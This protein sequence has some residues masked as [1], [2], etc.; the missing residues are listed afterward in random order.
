MT[1][2]AAF[3]DQAL[4]CRALGSPLTAQVCDGLAAAL[5]PE[6]GPVAQT[7]LNWPG[8]ASGRANS[9]PLR[10]AGA[11]HF[12]TRAGLV[13]D[14]A[15]AYARGAAPPDLMIR[16][17]QDHAAFVL[18]WLRSPPQTNEVARSAAIIAAAHFLR[19]ALPLAVMELGASAGLN[20]NWHRFRLQPQTAQPHPGFGPADS[21]VIL[22]P[23]W[24]GTPPPPADI[25]LASAQGVDLNPL[26][27]ARDGDR[28][29]AYC[30][31]DQTQRLDRLAAALAIAR[32]HPPQLVA[33]DAADW[34]AAQLAQPAP[35]QMRLIYHTIAWQYFPPE[36]QA[37]AEAAL[38]AAGAR[39]STDAP[40]AHFAMEADDAAPGAGLRLRLWDGNLRE[41]QLGRADFHGR[42]IDWTPV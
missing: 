17:L 4:A 34:L 32:A 8:D 2:R 28:L 14:L 3:A 25:R 29:L 39:A 31:A 15:A 36:A 22:R 18:D 16:A 30:W 38:Q 21:A 35:G 40:L 37:R 13:P 41:W 19:P 27:A 33:G 24:H 10:V 6:Q 23:E 11:L 12:L 42:W 20:L 5:Q 26:D 7:I 9:V 1:P